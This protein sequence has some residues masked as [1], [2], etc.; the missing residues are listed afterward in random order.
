MFCIE[1]FDDIIVV[2]SDKMVVKNRLKD[3]LD[4]RGLKQN[5]LAEQVGITKQTMSNLVK[6]RYTTSI[7]IAFKISRVLNVDFKDIFYEE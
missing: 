7:D 1:V 4:E 3:I 2:R 6:N 5:W